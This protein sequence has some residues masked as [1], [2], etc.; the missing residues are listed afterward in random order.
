M[1]LGR[2]RNDTK[3]LCDKSN[4]DADDSPST[5]A[6]ELSEDG[7]E[8]LPTLRSDHMFINGEADEEASPMNFGKFMSLMALMMT[9]ISS[10]SPPSLLILPEALR[11]DLTALIPKS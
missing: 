7:M 4:V 3:T 9:V 5:P 2:S 11:T 10:I 1:S 8:M 6:S